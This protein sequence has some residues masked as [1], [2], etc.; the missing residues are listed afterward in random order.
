[1]GRDKSF[2]STHESSTNPT[3]RSIIDS[4]VALPKS[5]KIKFTLKPNK[6]FL[7]NGETE[8]RIR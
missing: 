7:F 2:V 1:M 6:V 3:V 8:E 5:D 4:D